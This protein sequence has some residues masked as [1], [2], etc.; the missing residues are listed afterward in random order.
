MK[1]DTADP[2]QL[3]LDE[4]RGVY[5]PQ[6]FCQDFDI[7][8][9]QIDDS[10]AAICIAGPEHESYWDAWH[11]ITNT[12]KHI[13]TGHSLYQDGHLWAINYDTIPCAQYQEFF[14]DGHRDGCDCAEDS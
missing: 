14:G 10:D 8:D 12:A 13:T 9:W 1:T 7:S 5:I 2:L 11:E 3:L 6:T 4:C